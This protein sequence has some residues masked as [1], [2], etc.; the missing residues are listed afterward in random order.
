MK[1]I[2]Q[3][4]L[5][6]KFFPNEEECCEH[7]KITPQFLVKLLQTGKAGSIGIRNWTFDE[8]EGEIPKPLMK[9]VVKKVKT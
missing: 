1:I 6:T 9:K 7:F 8:W 3:T 2:A 5:L 4:D